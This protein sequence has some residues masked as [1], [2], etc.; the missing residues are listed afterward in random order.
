MNSSLRIVIL[1]VL[2]APRLLKAQGNLP[3]ISLS[4]PKVMQLAG[5]NNWTIR[6]F[7]ARYQLSLAEYAKSK[8]WYMPEIYT[9]FVTHY[10]NGA[11]MNTDG[12]I[13]TG[14]NRNFLWSGAGLAA[15]WDF[16]RGANAEK[17]ALLR[18]KEAQYQSQAGRN[19]AILEAIKTYLD[20]QAEQM[21][22]SVLQTL[23][24]QSDTLNR[25]I[26]IQVEAGLRYQSEYLL[27]QSNYQHY[28]LEW[29]QSRVEMEK[30]AAA[31]AALLNL[32]ESTMI[33]N[34]DTVLVPIQLLSAS[35]QDT[36]TAANALRQHPLYKSL[37][38]E[39]SALQWERKTTATGL[40][41]PTLRL[42]VD[43]AL[44]G[45]VATP[46]YNTGQ[47]NAALIW[48]LPLGRWVYKGDLRMYNGKI[49]LQ[50][51]LAGEFRAGL[52]Q[53]VIASR[54]AI[55]QAREQLTVAK[56]ALAT[57]AAGLQ[58]SLARQQLGTA[59]PF[60]VFQAQQFYR[61]AQLDYIG[62]VVNY[63]K[64]QYDLYVATGGSFL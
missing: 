50:E 46:W 16:N 43:D 8:E 14:I 42:S 29:L 54:A 3:V 55:R 49:A 1:F 10:L 27:A 32:A 62:V 15:Q 37:Q 57:S 39:L 23:L 51:A 5:A 28:R 35:Y 6:E 9:G 60:E 56:E 41:L 38:Q 13:Y 45:K 11:A 64:A 18:T 31:L 24:G 7:N 40:W 63:N 21:R 61:Q 52:Q 48:R 30:K 25:Q 33:V 44:F 2:L 19:Q 17:A 53:Q 26:Q 12:K 47:L 58:Q 4:L 22:Y 36:V 34:E 20:W 59:K